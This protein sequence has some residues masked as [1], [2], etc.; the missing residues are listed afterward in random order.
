MSILS[1]DDVILQEITN[2]TDSLCS[3]KTLESQSEGQIS[4]T[5]K[6]IHQLVNNNKNKIT[7]VWIP[8]YVGITGNGMADLITKIET[9]KESIEIFHSHD[10]N[11][12]ITNIVKYVNNNWQEKYTTASTGSVYRDIEPIVSKNIKYKNANRQNQVRITRLRLGKYRLKKYLYDLKKHN[13]GECV[14]SKVLETKKHVLLECFKNGLQ[15]QL[16]H[17][18]DQSGIH[19]NFRNILTNGS[20]IDLV[21]HLMTYLDHPL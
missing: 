3:V 15:E 12:E 11:H 10:I 14:D 21:Y 13:D 7:V 16:L 2:F 6:D 9:S 1:V 19:P 5:V 8:S 18:C 17:Q 20:T 4:N